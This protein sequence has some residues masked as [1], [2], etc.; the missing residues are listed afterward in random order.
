[1]LYTQTDATDYDMFGDDGDKQH[2]L[3]SKAA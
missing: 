3:E 1:M 2:P